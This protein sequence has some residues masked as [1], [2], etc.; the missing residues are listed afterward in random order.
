MNEFAEMTDE[1]LLAREEFLYDCELEG[2]DT[3]A[4]RDAVLWE[5]NRRGLCNG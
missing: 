5:M 2:Q 1:Q 4:E 3:W